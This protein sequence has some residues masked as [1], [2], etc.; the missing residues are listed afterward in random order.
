MM[1]HTVLLQQNQS[2]PNHFLDKNKSSKN[3][4]KCSPVC[5]R[6]VSGNSE[7]NLQRLLAIPRYFDWFPFSEKRCPIMSISLG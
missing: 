3:C 5:R 1:L 6:V 7:S 4:V 2:T